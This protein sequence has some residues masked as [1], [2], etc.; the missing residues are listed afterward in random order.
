MKY[1]HVHVAT[2]DWQIDY[3]SVGGGVGRIIALDK[4][5]TKSVATS[6]D[7]ELA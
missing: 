6:I 7:Y 1:I 2:I 3:D 4:I 5:I